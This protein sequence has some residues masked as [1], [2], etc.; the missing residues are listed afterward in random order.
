MCLRAGG[1]EG[2]AGEG[3]FECNLIHERKPPWCEYLGKDESGPRQSIKYNSPRYDTNG[4]SKDMCVHT[5]T[6]PPPHPRR[7]AGVDGGVASLMSE[8]WRAP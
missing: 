6:H 5:H 7:E 8:V 3:V 2:L 4:N 1:Q